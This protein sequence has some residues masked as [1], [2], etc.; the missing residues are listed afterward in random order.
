MRYDRRCPQECKYSL[1]GGK[2]LELSRTN[3][4]SV[5]EYKD[6]IIRLMDLWLRMPLEEFEGKTPKEIAGRESGR[7]KLIKY[8]NKIGLKSIYNA[9]YIKSKLELTEWDIPVEKENYEDVAKRYLNSILAGDV[10]SAL[11]DHLLGEQIAKEE[12]WKEDYIEQQA[13]DTVLKKMHDHALISSALSEDKKQALVMFDINGKFDLT[14]RLLHADDRW[15]VGSQINGKLEIVNSENEALQQVA[16]LLSKNELL[17]GEELLKKYK[18]LYPDSA[19]LHYYQGVM[20]ALKGRNKAAKK[21]FLRAVRLDSGFGEALYNYGLQLHLAGELEKAEINYNK[22]L[23]VEPD[24][25]K[26]LNNLAALMIDRGEL[27]KAEK[28][29][30]RCEEIDENYEPLQ[31]NSARLLELKRKEQEGINPA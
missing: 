25:I 1:Q 8:F 20:E 29:L 16:I 19:D 22:A 28:Y 11:R 5:E 10:E 27:D 18:N 17:Q 24:N 4:D 30:A 2:G 3:A 26:C 6:L 21:S 31:R 23:E 9:S 14:L 13:S 7:I 12:D 15:K